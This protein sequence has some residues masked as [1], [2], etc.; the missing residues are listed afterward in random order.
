M[1]EGDYSTYWTHVSIGRLIHEDV[2]RSVNIDVVTSQALQRGVCIGGGGEAGPS[3]QQPERWE[4]NVYTSQGELTTYPLPRMPDT[5]V[6]E[7]T[8]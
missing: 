7:L 6:S 5:A 3:M 1:A 2:Y 4:C 8:Q